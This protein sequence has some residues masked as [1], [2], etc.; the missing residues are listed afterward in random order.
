MPTLALRKLLMSKQWKRRLWVPGLMLVGQGCAQLNGDCMV[1]LRSDAAACQ[2]REASPN[3]PIAAFRAALD[4]QEQTAALCPVGYF[5]P[6]AEP[7]TVPLPIVPRID[8]S[9]TPAAPPS[10]PERS[11]ALPIGLDTVFRLAEEQNPQVALAR[12]RVR[13]AY[14]EKEVASRWL[15]D[16]YVGTAYYRHEG[17]IQNEDG[18]LTHSS[19]A[20]M[21]AGLEIDGKL[22][23]R[24]F[25]YQKVNAQRKV[26]QQRGEL[27]RVTSETLLGAASTYIDLLTARTGEAIAREIEGKLQGLLEHAERV[28]EVERASQVDVSRI[29][30]E[31]EAQQQTISRV[32]SQ[33]TGAAAKLIYLLGLDPSAELTPVDS[34]ILAFELVDAT[35]PAEYLVKKAQSSGPGVREMQ[36]LL[37]VIQDSI[38]Q[39]N[40]GLGKYLPIFEMRMGEGAF[41]AG[42]GDGMNW[43]NRWDMA[44][45]ARWNLSEAISARDRRHVAQA[46]VQQAHLVYRD[47][48]GKLAAGIQEARETALSGREQITLGERQIQDARRAFEL[49]DL[50]LRKNQQATSYSEALLALQA[51]GRAQVNY[52][53]ALNS[54]D[55]AQ[56]RLMVLLGPDTCRAPLAP[57]VH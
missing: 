1:A 44:V 38:D 30:A 7:E 22:D 43:D 53:S 20:A 34:R 12:E 37:G 32:R 46:K 23:V 39:G 25:A 21:F 18:T 47:L 50:R 10:A 17:G 33:A 48:E 55:K 2:A 6:P 15:P 4:A 52:L 27:S 16:I 11:N 24:E 49:S 35:P 14:A 36:G 41:G 40:N 8:R 13:E 3:V 51:L 56:L 57:A 29:R 28:T 19:S 9:E 45:Q 5:Q 31:L 26:W 42:P 54:Y